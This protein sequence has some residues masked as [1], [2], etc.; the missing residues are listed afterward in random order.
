MIF[1]IY[2]QLTLIGFTLH[3]NSYVKVSRKE[4][5]NNDINNNNNN[6]NNNNS[7]QYGKVEGNAIQEILS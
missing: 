5:D 7:E 2:K 6:N 3:C 4:C 1:R